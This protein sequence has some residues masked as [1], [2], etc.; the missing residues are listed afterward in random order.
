MWKLN[1]P[2]AALSVQGDEPSQ[3]MS[4]LYGAVTCF[5]AALPIAPSSANVGDATVPNAIFTA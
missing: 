1:P 5:A 4:W 3:R 2:H